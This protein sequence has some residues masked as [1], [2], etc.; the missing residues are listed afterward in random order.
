MAIPNEELLQKATLTTSDF[1]GPGQAALSVEAADSFIRH[2]YAD[3][4]MLG[5]VR[6]V[7]SRSSKWQEATLDF[8]TRIARPG[9]QATR[10]VDADRVKPTTSMIEISTVL[11]KGEVPISDEVFEDNIVGDRFGNELEQQIAARFGLDVEELM[12]AGDTASGDPYLALVD[13]WLK[14]AATGVG[15]NVVNAAAYGQD[16]GAIMGRLVVAMPDRYKRMIESDG[17]FYVPARLEEK[18]RQQLADR[19][20]A[21]GDQMLIGPRKELRYMGIEV[22]GVSTFPITAGSPDTSRILLSNRNNLYAGYRRKIQI[23]QFR[24]PREGATS[25]V[26]TARVAPAIGL[27]AGTAVAINVDVG[28]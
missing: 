12:V 10:L 11:I 2:M 13:G 7:T 4:K 5:D 23:E 26:I 22:R 18:W 17:R 21:L 19:G 24:D 28:L 20:T 3:Q 14:R 27:L 25:F 1:G 6:N 9:T 16:Y 15:G 8:A